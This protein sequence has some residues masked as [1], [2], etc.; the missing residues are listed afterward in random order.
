MMGALLSGQCD[1]SVIQELQQAGCQLG[2]VTNEGMTELM[3]GCWCR[4]S[5]EVLDYLVQQCGVSCVSEVSKA[6]WTGLMYGVW[7]GRKHV[8]EWYVNVCDK[9]GDGVTQQVVNQQTECGVTALMIGSYENRECVD[10]LFPI[11]NVNM[12]NIYGQTALHVAARGVRDED[13]GMYN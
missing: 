3:Y 5:E 9:L 1:V 8:V 11:A 6:G 2:Q 12:T 4:C 10:N 7:R 13:W